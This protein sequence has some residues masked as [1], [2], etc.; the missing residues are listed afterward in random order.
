VGPS[1][2]SAVARLPELGSEVSIGKGISSPAAT[3]EA[4]GVPESKSTGRMVWRACMS[5]LAPRVTAAPMLRCYAVTGSR[6]GGAAIREARCC[7]CFLV[8]LV[9]FQTNREYAFC[10]VAQFSRNALYALD[11]NT[12]AKTSGTPQ[13]QPT[14]LLNATC[15]MRLRGST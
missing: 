14:C 11:Q 13:V 5:W 6:E 10:D 9:I 3:I 4:S 8:E 1:R 2:V 12:T 15:T 7:W